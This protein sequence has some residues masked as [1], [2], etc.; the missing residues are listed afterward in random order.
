MQAFFMV[1]TS[2]QTHCFTAIFTGMALT[3]EALN[4]LA[5]AGFQNGLPFPLV[6]SS[7][8][9]NSFK[10]CIKAICRFNRDEKEL[11]TLV[12]CSVFNQL[13]QLFRDN[14]M[15]SPDAPSAC[16]LTP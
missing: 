1:S 14:R 10:H 16:V 5:F 4:V 3:Y 11:N 6:L 15:L 12:L 7:G 8:H 2:S 13:K 9:S